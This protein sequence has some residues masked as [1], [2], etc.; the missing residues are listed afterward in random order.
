MR[1]LRKIAADVAE[2]EEEEN[3]RFPGETDELRM[4]Y[5]ESDEKEFS[6]SPP[7][8]PRIKV[9]LSCED[10]DE[11]VKDLSQAVKSVRGRIVKAEMSTIGGRTKSELVIERR[12]GGGGGREEYLGML[13]RALKAVV[14]KHCVSGRS[15]I[16]FGSKRQ[17][18]SHQ[19]FQS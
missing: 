8:P 1:E 5:C 3:W 15:Q 12:G 10:R 13:K 16:L 2:K 4:S 14:D 11:L 18:L 19:L 9:T 17:R 7:P 6:S